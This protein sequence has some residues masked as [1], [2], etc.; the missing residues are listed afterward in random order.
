MGEGHP[1]TPDRKG[2]KTP[3]S[4]SLQGKETPNER[5]QGSFFKEGQAPA[6]SFWKLTEKLLGCYSVGSVHVCAWAWAWACRGHNSSITVRL[7]PL[8]QA[9]SSPGASNTSFEWETLQPT[10]MHRDAC[11]GQAPGDRD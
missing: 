5:E 2:T 9:R 4:N 7:T 11:G 8:P 1:G 6:S 3:S 10:R